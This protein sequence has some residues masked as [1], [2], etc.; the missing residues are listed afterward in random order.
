MKNIYKII[1]SI[2][3]LF[4]IYL[5]IEYLKD[6]IIVS[7]GGYTHQTTT[8][9]IDSTFVKGKI[10]T[11]EIFNHYVSTHGINLNTVPKIVYLKKE[12]KKEVIQDSLKQNSITV[13]D[14]IIDGVF[15]VFNDFKGNVINSEFNYKPIYPRIIKQTD[16]LKVYKTNNIVQSNKRALLGLGIDVNTMNFV[17]IRASYLS[18]NNWQFIGGYGRNMMKLNAFEPKYLS[19]ITIMYHF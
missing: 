13:K 12:V 3:A 6:K 10:D 19:S 11:L 2:I 18:K 14:S 16:T 17:S 1:I 9:V 4:V 8:T 7:L 15:T 5:A